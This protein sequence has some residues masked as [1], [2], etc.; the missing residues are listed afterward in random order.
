MTEVMDLNQYFIGTVVGYDVNTR[1]VDVFI[2]KLMPAIPD[3]QKDRTSLTNLG[4]PNINIKY[5]KNITMS[6]SIKLKPYDMDSPLPEI[7]SK[8]MVFFL[9]GQLRWGYWSKFNPNGDYEV[10][11]SEKYE[12]LYK[13]QIGDKEVLIKSDDKVEIELPEGFNV[14]LTEDKENKIKHFR[15]SQDSDLVSRLTQ[16]ENKVGIEDSIQSYIDNDGNQQ[17]QAFVSSGLYKKIKK[18]NTRI[19]DLINL[20]GS[21]GIDYEYTKIE[22]CSYEHGKHY[23]VLSEG[24]YTEIEFD[25]FDSIIEKEGYLQMILDQGYH[26]Y[27]R[28]SVQG[29]ATGIYARLAALEAKL[30]K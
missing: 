2:P 10:I 20:I 26:V 27:I 19:D 1:E 28:K 23:C 24:E 3:G 21:N 15:V 6:S 12:E 8:V 11:E 4:N 30:N 5:N 17:E 29:D 13:L 18:T 16:L 25:G 14:I 22:T 9:E 7:N